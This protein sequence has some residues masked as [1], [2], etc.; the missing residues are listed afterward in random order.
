M[1]AGHC[2]LYLQPLSFTPLPRE[3]FCVPPRARM[4]VAPKY[5]HI[6]I[7][8][9]HGCDLTWQTGLCICDEAQNYSGEEGNVVTRVLLRQSDQ[10][11]AGGDAVMDTETAGMRFEDGG[12]QEPRNAG[13]L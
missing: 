13:D 7:P 5:V 2:S 11:R 12:R 4:T 3:T 6:L 1:G 9:T 8:G 10:K